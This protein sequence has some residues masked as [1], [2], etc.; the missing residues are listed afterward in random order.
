MNIKNVHKQTF[1]FP[2]TIT[3]DIVSQCWQSVVVSD[4][5]LPPCCKLDVWTYVKLRRADW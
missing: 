2:N 3:T 5:K 1:I 4:F